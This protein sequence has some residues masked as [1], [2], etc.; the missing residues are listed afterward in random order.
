MVEPHAAGSDVTREG[1]E[2]PSLVRARGGAL[3]TLSADAML[4]LVRITAV[5]P[6][7]VDVP[8]RA[9]VHGVHGIA[10]VQ[11]SVLVRVA[12]DGGLEGWGN[13]DPTPGYSPVSA[14]DVHVGASTTISSGGITT[15]QSG[16]ST[17]IQGAPLLLN[18]GG[19][20]AARTGDAVT[21]TGSSGVITTGSTSV[22]IGD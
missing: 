21:V 10:A 14:D 19:H 5:E 2:R 12:T 22:F 15:I 18:G 7:L 9:P 20:P 3:T 17:S 6:I 8:L 16:G 13:V 11:R 4:A 1:A